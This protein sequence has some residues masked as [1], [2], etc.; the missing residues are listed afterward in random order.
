[1]PTFRSTRR[2]PHAPGPMFDLVA[3]VERYPE[4]LPMC[5]G[6][7]VLRRTPAGD[8]QSATIGSSAL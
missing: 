6:L 7:R 1:M 3:D 8:G 5:E 2:V 4:F